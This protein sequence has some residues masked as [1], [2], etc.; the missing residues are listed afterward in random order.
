MVEEKVTKG[1]YTYEEVLS[2]SL[3]YFNGDELAATTWINKYALKTSDGT[4]KEL[5]P[6]DMHRRMAK[7]FGRIEAKYNKVESPTEDKALRMQYQL[8]Q[9]NKSGL[10]QQIVNREQ[11]LENLE[12][13]WLC[14][15]GAEAQ[16]QVELNERFQR[17][18]HSK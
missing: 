6:D 12:L 2:S 11:Q 13:D 4:Y 1:N 14:M 8:D 17:V 16:I 15:P 18:L 3:S 5:T 10:G 9:M 7:E